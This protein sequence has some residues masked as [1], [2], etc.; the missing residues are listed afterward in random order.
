MNTDPEDVLASLAAERDELGDSG[1]TSVP[2]APAELRPRLERGLAAAELLR[3]FCRA[4]LADTA[5]PSADST[6]TPAPLRRVGRFSLRGELGRGAFGVVFLAHDPQLDRDVALKLA[7]PSVLVNPELIARFREEA[8]AAAV[9]D[10]PHI[11]AVH[12]AGE[13]DGVSWIASAYCPGPSLAAWVRDRAEP[14]PPRE[15]AELLLRLAEAVE[16]AHGRGILHRD[17]KPAN[18]LLAGNREQGTGNREQAGG[19]RDRGVGDGQVY[20]SSQFPVRSSLFPRITDFGLA[21]RLGGAELT[22]TGAVL[23]T[24]SYMAPEQTSVGRQALTAATDVYGLGAIL[25]EVLTGRPPFV[26]E[27]PLHTLDLVRSADPIPPG[28]LRP[29]LPRDLATICL[30]CLAKEPR[31]RYPTAQALA[32][33]LSRFLDGRPVLARPLGRLARGWRWCRRNPAVAALAAALA[34]A[35]AAGFTGVLLKWQEADANWQDAVEA[36][37]E[38]EK[39][40]LKEQQALAKEKEERRLKDAALTRASANAYFHGVNLAHREWRAGNVS[41]ALQVLESC[42]ADWRHWEWDLLYRLCRMQEVLPQPSPLEQVGFAPDGGHLWTAGRDKM[43]RGRPLTGSKD[44]FALRGARAWPGRLPLDGAPAECLLVEGQGVVTVHDV[45]TGK[46][47]RTIE[48]P[49][50]NFALLGFSADGNFLAYVEAQKDIVVRETLAGTRVGTLAGAGRPT[51]GLGAPAVAVGPDGRMLAL[52]VADTVQLWDV[53]AGKL[54]NTLR[55]HTSIIRHILFMPDGSLLVTCGEDGAAKL[56]GAE[57]GREQQTYRGHLGSVRHAALSP[58]GKVLATAGNDK[59]VRLWET[60][61]GRERAVLRGHEHVVTCVAFDT[62]GGRLASAGYDNTV[63]L[64]DARAGQELAIAPGQF[65]ATRA[66]SFG[67]GS[68]LHLVRTDGTVSSWE[69]GADREK[70]LNAGK[71][72]DVLAAALCP[73]GRWLVCSGIA[74]PARLVDL[75]GQLPERVLSGHAGRVNAVAISPGERAVVATAGE[76][77]VVKLWDAAT[78]QEVMTLKGFPD[79]VF[80]VSFSS[81]GRQLAAGGADGIVRV[82]SVP[83]GK[84]LWTWTGHGTGALRVAFGPGGRLA[85]AT[86]EGSIQVAAAV[87]D[88]APLA[89]RGHA[90]AVVALAFS[91]DGLRLASAGNDITLKLWDTRTGHEALAFT[92]PAGGVQAVAFSNDGRHLAAAGTDH[93]VRVWTAAPPPGR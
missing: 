14:V 45:A 58:D 86:F 85:A 56:W 62:T 89:L 65:L 11:V 43:V 4:G 39:A 7:Q 31:H 22:A 3:R 33:D 15:A 27:S 87:P 81:D 37:K 1:D 79:A 25:Y 12:D 52:A 60:H 73:R 8:R 2:E 41:Y 51:P 32:D 30:K 13:S 54:R 80:S 91:P 71:G 38:R 24:P 93:K 78:G 68:T 92:G 18:V 16:H 70:A 29:R 35:V 23:G 64:W 83:E 20:G 21:K 50:A 90:G 82:W 66:L 74:G 61:S 6:A 34:F 77:G 55:G 75:A 42:P 67:P 59:T 10:H 9:L 48:V 69:V 88:A 47:L 53:P 28:E 84:L 5:A 72:G 40:L 49:T 17:L 57:D 63:R 44:R 46:L 76:D 26:G 36:G 19:N